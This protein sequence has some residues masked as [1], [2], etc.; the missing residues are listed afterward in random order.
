MNTRLMQC[1]SF[2]SADYNYRAAVKKAI[3]QLRFLDDEPLTD[4]KETLQRTSD[5]EDDWKLLDELMMEGAI[6][7]PDECV[8]TTGGD[9]HDDVLCLERNCFNC[10]PVRDNILVRRL[11]QD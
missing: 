8:E 1:F 2:Q 11:I 9:G 3:P 7:T 4:D 5:F 6:L 10:L